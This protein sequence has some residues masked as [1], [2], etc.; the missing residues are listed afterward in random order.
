MG[1]KVPVSL[2]GVPAHTTSRTEFGRGYQL[3]YLIVTS[4]H[5]P[6][7]E[8]LLIPNGK[9]LRST[10][11][12]GSPRA[13]LVALEQRLANRLLAFV[14]ACYI[15]GQRDYDCYS[16]IHYL[17]GAI[18]TPTEARELRADGVWVTPNRLSSGRAYEVAHHDHGV[19]AFLA[20]SSQLGLSISGVNGGLTI[21]KTADMMGAYGGTRLLRV[22]RYIP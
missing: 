8:P 7:Q 18:R 11:N 1:N 22:D 3:S 9:R 14:R 19:H 15:E 5:T 13:Q 12:R 2:H 16:F 4:V 6:E 10:I 21:I 17:L 20:I